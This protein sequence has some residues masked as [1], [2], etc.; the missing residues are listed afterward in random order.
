MEKRLTVLALVFSLLFISSSACAEA[1]FKLEDVKSGK[2]T[3]EQYFE[4]L[5]ENTQAVKEAKEA[6][7]LKGI[8]YNPPEEELTPLLADLLQE[9]AP[10]QDWERLLAENLKVFRDVKE[11]G[12]APFMV[13]PSTITLTGKGNPL[14]IIGF[15]WSLDNVHTD[16]DIGNI[17]LHELQHVRDLSQGVPLGGQLIDWQDLEKGSITVEFWEHWLE[18]RAYRLEL[19]NIIQAYWKDETNKY[20]KLYITNVALNY[21]EHYDALSKGG[22]SLLEQSLATAQL[23]DYRD[24]VPTHLGKDIR[25]DFNIGGRRA[26]IWLQQNNTGW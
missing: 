7:L 10:N 18:L 16:G 26:S 24:I 1:P 22:S 3:L 15:P 6:G 23:K 11:K 4:Q 25:L 19:V 8:L 17:L 12:R 20:S 14:Y 21:T 9:E 13:V 2:I 5:E